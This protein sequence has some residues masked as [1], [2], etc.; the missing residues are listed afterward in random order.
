NFIIARQSQS[1]ETERGKTFNG[2]GKS[3]LISLIHFCLGSSTKKPFKSHIPDWTFYLTFKIKGLEYIASRNTSNQNVINLNGQDLRVRDFNL[4][5]ENLL[6]DVPVSVDSLSF[7]SLIPSFIRP[8]RASY[9]SF[10]NP[11]TLK[12]DYSI[13][14]TNSFLLG[15][16][17]HLVQQKY[18]LRKSKE[19]IRYLVNEIKDDQLLRSFFVGGRDILLATQNLEDEIEKLESDLQQF[20][21]AEDYYEIKT[22][23]DKLQRQLQ[24]VQNKIV[25]RQN[26]VKNIDE[27]RKLSPDIN[28]D[29]IKKIYEEASIVI[30][31]VA[32][33]RLD[34]LENFYR[35]LTENREKRLL[36]QK[37]EINR[38]ISGLSDEFHRLQIEFDANLKYLD[39]HQALDVFVN[40]TTKL[41]DLRSDKEKLARYNQ[42]LEEYHK[43]KIRIEREFI[44]ATEETDKYLKDAEGII[45][46]TRE[47]FRELAKR[48]YPNSAAGV[49]VYNNDGDNLLRFNFDAKIESDSSDG[50]NN[51]KIF[52]YDLT[53]SLK[54][55]NHAVGTIFHDS[56]LLDGVD[57]RQVAE[58]FRCLR[59][60]I[61]D[62]RQ[63]ILTINQNHLDEIVPYLT[64]EEYDL[65][66][67]AN[68]CHELHDGSPSGKLLGIQV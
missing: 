50:I 11:N 15:L 40:L 56:R 22:V 16:N 17:V 49:T 23:A 38:E 39:T 24:Q 62:S 59:D 37:T 36:D 4:K 65:I 53:L 13:L 32:L 5:L 18:A 48:F 34:E 12:D 31:E 6:F 51:V 55:F 9:V 28:N 26:Q 64:K 10:K 54:G 27:S 66:V 67:A 2:V 33:K 61:G 44:E 47:F 68:V 35:H 19:R 8:R 63:Y 29:A 45:R 1:Q 58:M 46:S 7:R 20:R 57:P 52:C 43:E 25:L 3:L 21:L 14:L 41:S 30:S 60:Y 42:L